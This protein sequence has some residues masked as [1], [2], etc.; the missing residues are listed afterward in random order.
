MKRTPLYDRHVALG[1]RIVP[2]AG[3][4]MPIQYQGIVEETRAVRQRAGLFDVSHMGRVFLTG[5]DAG[6]LLRRVLTFAVHSLEPG[7]S[8]YTLMCDEAGGILDD[9][10]LLRLGEQRWLLIPNAARV[11]ADLAQIRAHLA[12]GWDVQIDDRQAQTLMPALQGPAAPAVLGAVLSHE[13]AERLPRRHHME[14]E[15]YGAKAVL[16]R[17]G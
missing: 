12:P 8:H 16:S 6:A 9:P 13:L 5:P 14:L 2:F 1:G 15:L 7:R 3:W 4:E 11:E 10:Y 17:T